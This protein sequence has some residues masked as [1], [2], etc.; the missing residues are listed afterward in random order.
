[1]YSDNLVYFL[2]H[3][4]HIKLPFTVLNPYFVSEVVQVL[5]KICPG[6]KS[7]RQDLRV[8]VRYHVP[9]VDRY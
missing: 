9:H 1:M 3:F 5:N 7:I 2:G 6:C 8:K 4:G